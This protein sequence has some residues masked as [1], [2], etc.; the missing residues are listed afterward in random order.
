MSGDTIEVELDNDRNWSYLKKD[1]LIDLIGRVDKDMF[2]IKIEV[3][4][5]YPSQRSVGTK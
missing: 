3:K 1:E 5:A 4:K 2:S